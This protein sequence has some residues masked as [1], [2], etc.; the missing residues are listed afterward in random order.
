[1]LYHSH[2]SN[3]A[4][5]LWIPRQTVGGRTTAVAQNIFIRGQFWT[6]MN[7][8]DHQHLPPITDPTWQ[9]RGRSSTWEK[10]K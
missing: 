2:L 8:G 4:F 6:T 7:D 3:V 5:G 9:S 1:M 10:N